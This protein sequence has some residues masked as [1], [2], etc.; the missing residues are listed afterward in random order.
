MAGEFRIIIPGF[1]H[2]S[3]LGVAGLAPS[4]IGSLGLGIASNSPE[5]VSVLSD[6]IMSH[7]IALQSPTA[8]PETPGRLFEIRPEIVI[9]TNEVGSI[10]EETGILLDGKKAD[11]EMYGAEV[12]ETR[13]HMLKLITEEYEGIADVGVTAEKIRAAMHERKDQLVVDLECLSE[14]MSRYDKARTVYESARLDLGA[15]EGEL[16]AAQAQ[17]EAL[18]NRL[19]DEK[20]QLTAKL[21]AVQAKR[22]RA[23][24]A[25]QN[26]RA[27]N[28]RYGTAYESDEEEEE[29]KRDYFMLPFSE[30]ELEN[31]RSQRAANERQA[32]WD[33]GYCR[34]ASVTRSAIAEVLN[35]PWFKA[36]ADKEEEEIR[37]LARPLIDAINTEIG[38]VG[39]QIGAL[40][41]QVH[42][43]RS[44]T[45]RRE[46]MVATF[47]SQAQEKQAKAERTR[48]QLEVMTA[49]AEDLMSRPELSFEGRIAADYLRSKSPDELLRWLYDEL[50][51]GQVPEL[52]DI[53]D[54]ITARQR[55][56]ASDRRGLT[57]G[58]GSRVVLAVT[59]G[60]KAVIKK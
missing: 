51:V 24:N 12:A 56:I 57:R 5:D 28:Q 27:R 58:F 45:K 2:E 48:L 37:V 47:K 53:A 14:A 8:S 49:A 13:E 35:A 32:N 10:V 26:L 38:Q 18:K 46:E 19:K 29:L 60:H 15:T 25:V 3:D 1:D 40:S 16:T 42:S 9:A 41:K 21:A 50:D 30:E 20:A 11:A 23:A 55:A 31:G 36:L 17:L 6:P 33:G 52:H 59:G 22:D 43:K 39:E 54:G 7:E 4:N 34:N 44:L